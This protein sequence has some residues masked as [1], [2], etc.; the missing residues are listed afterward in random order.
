MFELIVCLLG[1]NESLDPIGGILD[2]LVGKIQWS[3]HSNDDTVNVQMIG[4]F[5]GGLSKSGPGRESSVIRNP[6]LRQKKGA[7]KRKRTKGGDEIA[8]SKSKKK[9]ESE[10]K[11]NSNEEVETINDDFDDENPGNVEN[12]AG[13]PPHARKGKG[14]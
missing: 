5:R 9:D 14:K 2:L 6:S 8:Q 10:E 1:D 13:R 12:R 7:P 4:S 11:A 3:D